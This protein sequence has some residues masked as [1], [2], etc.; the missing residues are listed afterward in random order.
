MMKWFKHMT[1]AR[2]DRAIEK[3]ILEY[4]VR[5]YGLYFYCL[6]IIAGS[7]D[8]ANITFELEPDAEILA[9][10]LTMDTLEVER[11]MH[12]CIELG[13]FEIADNGRITCFKI[14]KFLDIA[15]TSNQEVR[16]IIQKWRECQDLPAI[17]STSSAHSQDSSAH[18]QDKSGTVRETLINPDQKRREEKR[19]EEN[20]EKKSAY[21]LY[22]N[23][24]LTLADLLKLGEQYGDLACNQLIERLS[25]YKESSGKKYA[26]DIAA[27]RNW[28]VKATGVQP[29][30]PPATPCP[31]CGNPL[32]QG[33]CGNA[34][35]PQWEE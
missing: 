22:K 8:S 21:G 34:E 18:S 32:D 7:V 6:E 11:I 25:S 23:V 27:I 19:R 4:G 35:C 16:K 26:S 12:R 30:P 5:G 1:R 31:H 10:R 13:L 2:E 33:I 20:K 15:A 9:R 28:V 29:L 3:L 14:G 17:V 24:Y